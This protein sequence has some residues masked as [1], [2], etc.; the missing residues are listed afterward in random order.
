MKYCPY[1]KIKIEGE[2][3]RCPLCHNQAVEVEG[4][5]YE[6]FPKL[7]TI[8][9]HKGFLYRILQFLSIAAAVISLAI[10][11]AMPG[12]RV[13]W[14]LFVLAAIGCGWLC[15]LV[16]I[17][18]RHNPMK[19]LIWQVVL[20]MVLAV[21]WDIGTGWRGWS[22]DFVIPALLLCAMATTLVLIFAL[23]IQMEDSVI[24]IC[25]LIALGLVPVIFIF[26]DVGHFLYL[27]L[28]CVVASV[29]YLAALCTLQTS[30]FVAQLRRRFHL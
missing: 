2:H 16:F 1:C 13:W 6:A 18:K 7:T 12:E 26:T 19:A 24:Y 3:E 25:M 9:P 30:S 28:A 17:R 20:G 11:Y 15:L 29:L 10:N 8:V 5:R 21:A 27:S 23:H 14:S 22:V 4:R